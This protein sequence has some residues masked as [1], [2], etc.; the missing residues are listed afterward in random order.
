MA[1]SKSIIIILLWICLVSPYPAPAEIYRYVDENGI[2]V[3]TDKLNDVPIDQRKGEN[4][5]KEVKTA[6]VA[7]EAATPKKSGPDL[8]EKKQLE[9]EQQDLSGIQALNSRGQELEQEYERLVNK[10][11]ALQNQKAA[12][13]T[14][15]DLAEYRGK[16][17]ALNGEIKDFEKRRKA[18]ETEVNNFNQGAL[19]L[20]KSP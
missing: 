7:I 10:K 3:Y 4:R 2:V 17:K 15:Q 6:P 11:Q 16:L 19:E 18:F 9:K 12:I 20:K 13:K 5:V 1:K 8:E 14:G